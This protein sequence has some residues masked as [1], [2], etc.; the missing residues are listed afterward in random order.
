[1]RVWAYIK[2]TLRDIFK[3][4]PLLVFTI[5][6]FPL[7]LVFILGFFMDNTSNILDIPS[8]KV[9]I[10]DEDE[11]LLSN[12][13]TQL[14]SNEAYN[15]FIQIDEEAY[16]YEI[17]IPEGYEVAITQYKPL[18]IQVKLGEKSSS[19]KADL[20]IS[21]IDVYNKEIHKGMVINN[22]L[23]KR[24]LSQETKKQVVNTIQNQLQ[25]INEE[26]LFSQ[27]I[28]ESKKI[29]TSFENYSIASYS[30]SFLL[31]VMIFL[32]SAFTEKDLGLYKRINA[33]PMTRTQYYNYTLMSSGI[34]I[35]IFN[36]IYVLVLRV[37]GL[38]FQGRLID[39]LIIQI[40]MTLVASALVGFLWA[41]MNKSSSMIVLNT[42]MMIQMLINVGFRYGTYTAESSIMNKIISF[43]PDTLI[44][45]TLDGYVLNGTIENV[46]HYL[47]SLL[48]IGL[49]CYLMGLIKANIRW[50]NE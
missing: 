43:S 6:I 32:V 9:M 49:I 42:I 8:I 12:E 40:I 29:F 47:L 46:K 26:E 14:L 11:S 27:K 10:T 50:R 18:D 39:L 30:F 25:Q 36:M 37:L 13:L 33:T 1:M 2:L 20:L 5:S 35:F 22:N 7:G 31:L 28:V 19:S 34:G 44:T 48:I 45:K 38:S 17:I 41:F 16:N 4:F 24:H 23:E 21:V 3:N 15:P